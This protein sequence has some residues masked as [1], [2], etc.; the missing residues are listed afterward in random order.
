M[1]KSPS[2]SLKTYALSYFRRFYLKKTTIDYDPDYMVCAALFLGFKNAQ[3]SVN[4]EIMKNLCPFL[5][6]KHKE[7]NID[8]VYLLLDNE[9]YMIN[10]LNYDFYIFCPYKA[11][12]GLINT[13]KIN[14]QSDS[15][16]DRERDRD[17]KSLSISISININIFNESV[18]Q[19]NFE[20]KC[21]SLIDQT[22]LTDLIFLYTHSY[23][24]LACVF[25][26]AESFNIKHDT[27]KSILQLETK[28]NYTNFYDVILPNVR[29]QI[30]SIKIITDDEFA[31]YKKKILKFLYKNP[32]Y[33]EKIE[34]DRAYE[35][36][37]LFIFFSG[38][39]IKMSQFSKVFDDETDERNINKSA[40]K[41]KDK[42]MVDDEQKLIPHKRERADVKGENKK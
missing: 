32:K 12:I 8:N 13:L 29:E 30:N 16:S 20:T 17:D 15:D 42:M 38:I 39:K 11:M 5:K 26:T 1:K 24:A 34:K 18:T 41:D 7:K 23:I 3:M 27:I 25:L 14:T 33:V 6:E 2:R 10:V 9:F 40:V 21:E 37:N 28:I 19:K 35:I 36:S 4:I 22:F 31:N